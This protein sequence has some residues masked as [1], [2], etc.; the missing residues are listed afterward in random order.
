MFAAAR[1]QTIVCTS[2]I[3]AAARFYEEVLGLTCAS[4]SH[5]ARVYDVG[6]AELRLSP[7][8][9]TQP[10]AHTVVGFAIQD[11]D[12]VVATLGAR[13]V[14]FERFPGFP[15]DSRAIVTL[16]EGTRVA[17]LRDPDGN[18]LSIVQYA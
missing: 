5:G 8:P 10:S 14:S 9:S 12:R 4:V 1:L 17:W 3:D 6:G 2:R 16:P 15:H 18:L 13:G 11:L 7:V